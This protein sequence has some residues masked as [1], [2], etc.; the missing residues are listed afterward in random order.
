[1]CRSSPLVYRKA[2]SKMA[3]KSITPSNL[4]VEERRF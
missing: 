1:M 4:T 3:A 2:H